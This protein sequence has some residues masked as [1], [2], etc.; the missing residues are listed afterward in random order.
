MEATINRS[1][2]AHLILIHT[3]SRLIT[4]YLQM[5][6]SVPVYCVSASVLCQCVLC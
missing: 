4:G 6:G 2:R 3:S 5:S 1:D